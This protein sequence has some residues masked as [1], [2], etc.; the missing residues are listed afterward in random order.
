MEHTPLQEYPISKLAHSLIELDEG[1]DTIMVRD[2]EFPLWTTVLSGTYARA[3]LFWTVELSELR[4][5]IFPKNP[6]RSTRAQ[7][8]PHLESLLS[9]NF[10]ELNGPLGFHL[11]DLQLALSEVW[12]LEHEDIVDPTPP[13]VIIDSILIGAPIVRQARVSALSMGL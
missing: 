3:K 12:V 7:G 10:H 1:L 5:D 2:L 4:A 8:S 6:R 9:Q 13:C 11:T